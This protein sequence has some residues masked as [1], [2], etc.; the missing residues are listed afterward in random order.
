MNLLTVDD[1]ALFREGL[2]TLLANISPGVTIREAGCVEDAITE[3]RASSFR[4]VLL[5]L[6]LSTTHGLGTLDAFRAA[7]PEVPVIVVSGDDDKHNITGAIDLGAVGFI[8]KAHTSKL[9]IAALQ[10]VLAGGIYLPPN[11]LHEH[12]AESSA[13]ATTKVVAAAYSR[14]SPRQQEVAT[15]LLQ[16]KSNKFIARILDI[17]EGTVKAHVSAIFQ[18]LGAKSRVEAVIIASKSGIKVL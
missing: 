17:S 11:L 1:H 13:A 5:D 7:V 8:P 4:M 2:C 3:C 9:M 6:S 12:S 16:G 15:L 10:F 18:I 14:L